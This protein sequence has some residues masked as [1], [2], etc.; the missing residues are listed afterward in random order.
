MRINHVRKRL[1][2]G[3]PSI[4]TW[5]SLPSPEAAEQVSRLPL[6]WLVVDAEHSAVDIRTL[7]QMFTSMS[8][9]GI[10]PMV[11]IPWN[12][13]ENFKRV[14]DAGAW[15]V[16]V[17]MVNNREEAERAVAAARYYPDGNRSVGGGR[18]ALSWDS[19]GAEYYRNANDQVLVVL[20]IEH[21]EGVRNADE[22]LSVPGVDACFIGPNDLAAS[23][24]LGLGV[25]LESD[26]P[27][28]VEAIM[29]IRDTCLKHGVA[30]GIH[31]SGAEGVNF[32]IGQGFQFCAM[33]SEMR[34]MV[35]FL[36]EDADKLDWSPTQRHQQLE[37]EAAEAGVTVRY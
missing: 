6:D 25:P 4:G 9:S 26:I 22:I 15:G 1:Q 11:R 10:A 14:L 19:S 12:S 7:A 37:A 17:P 3:E 20:Q 8:S 16:V 28:L 27:E 36:K 24:G 34:Y 32:R 33:A 5:M 30:T 35:G 31:T 2:A 23:M 29:H 13:A 18:H 21:I